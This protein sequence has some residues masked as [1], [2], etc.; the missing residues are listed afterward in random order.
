MAGTAP[1]GSEGDPVTIRAAAKTDVGRQRKA[2]ED[3]VGVFPELSL[4][5]VADG[6]GGHA[7]GE[8][9]SAMTIEAIQR[10]LAESHDEDLTPVADSSGHLS[11][12]GRLLMIALFEANERILDASSSNPRL[13]GMG[14][15]AVALQ[16]DPKYNCVAICHVGDTRA[17]RVREG[18]AEQLTEDHTVVQQLLKDGKITPDEIRTSPHRHMLTQALGTARVVH[19]GLRLVEPAPGDV[20]VLCSDG[21]HDL[22]GATE[23][24]EIVRDATDINAACTRL[25]DLANDRGGHDNSTVVVV[26]CDDGAAGDETSTPA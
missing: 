20:F 23:I 14:A 26:A 7:A 4:F 21:I 3:A 8:V 11:L 1:S 24:A 5:V 16:F 25:I 17:Y 22:V 15:A 6:V 13:Q 12:G 10:S 2:N 19:P 9:A 18:V